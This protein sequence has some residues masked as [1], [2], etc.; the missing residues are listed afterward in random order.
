MPFPTDPNTI[1]N[2]VSNA[3][4]DSKRQLDHKSTSKAVTAQNSATNCTPGW[5]SPNILINQRF[6][7]G[8]S[9][10]SFSLHMILNANVIYLLDRYL[11]D[12]VYSHDSRHLPPVSIAISEVVPR[13]GA[14]ILPDALLKAPS[15]SNCLDH[16]TT[17]ASLTN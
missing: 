11:I 12:N 4:S 5:K 17:S 8:W 9:C 16:G 1:E 14:H 10:Q 6:L 13:L 7:L 3:K 2:R 15:R